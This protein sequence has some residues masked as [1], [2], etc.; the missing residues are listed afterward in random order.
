[1]KNII[2]YLK[3]NAADC[4]NKIFCVDENV[5]YSYLESFKI[6]K[7]VASALY[8]K[9][10]KNSP[11]LIRAD[12]NC[13][14]LL[15]MLGV[16]MSNNYYVP[17]NPEFS[18]EKEE[19]VI[20]SS[21]IKYEISFNGKC[22]D[23]LTV[24]SYESMTSFDEIEGIFDLL[25]KDFNEDNNMYTIYTSGSTGKPKGVLKTQKNIISFVNNFV[26]TFK[27]DK[28]LNIA[29]QAPLF[30][31]ASMKDVYLALI[32]CSTL[33][34]PNKSLFA[35]PV[36]LIEYLNENKIDYICWVP[37]ALSII[38]R[39]KTFNYIKPEYLKYVLFV[40]EVFMPKYLNM[41]I[42]DLPN[43]KYVNLYGSS[44]LAGICL[45]KEINS[46]LDEDKPIA[47]GKALANNKVYLEN[48]EIVVESDQIATCYVN[49]E[50]KNKQ[51]FVERDNTRILKTG[52][53]AF[54]NE[55]GDIVFTSRKDFQIKHMGYRIELQEIDLS[56]SALDYIDNC[57]VLFDNKKD[58][59]VSFVSLNKNVESPVKRIIEDLKN[60]I[61]NYM[62]PNKVVILDNLPLNANGKIDRVKLKG[63]LE[64]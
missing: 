26:E 27:F 64:E 39:L 38:V 10:I 8:N 42:K 24:F 37:S 32:N 19:S 16:I 44:E 58:K 11:I 50:E 21:N 9:G 18:I 25:S 35:M 30:F 60:K 40:G 49:D 3:N 43:V 29:N 5:N 53:Y 51:V 4:P 1:M 56:V 62:V 55:E 52:D 15:T 12:R 17:I 57:A 6:A 33:Y 41:W 63:L 45:Y 31:D 14:T 2:E 47:L 34:F 23:N 48:G 46:L 28:G 22:N 20:E 7:K 59:I 13:D 61:P 36:K 54:I